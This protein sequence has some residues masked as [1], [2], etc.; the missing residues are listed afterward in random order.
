MPPRGTG[1]VTPFGAAD[2]FVCSPPYQGRAGEVLP[3]GRSIVTADTAKA[4]EREYAAVRFEYAVNGT[5]VSFVMGERWRWD[6]DAG[7]NPTDFEITYAREFR[8]DGAR[9]R[10]LNR[11]LDPAALQESGQLVSLRDTWSDYSGDSVYA[12]YSFDG[13]APEVSRIYEPGV[14]MSVDPTAVAG[15]R[16][17]HADHLGT[18]RFTSDG[19]TGAVVDS[20][21][22]EALGAPIDG[23]NH[24]YGYAG[25]YGY[26]SHDIDEV[27][28]LDPP[29]DPATAFPFLHVGARY[30]DP[31]TGRF[32]QRDPIGIAG[33]LNVYA[34][35]YNNP[36]LRTDPSGNGFW[37]GNN[38]FHDWIAR[39]FWMHPINP[40]KSRLPKMGD[41]EACAW[42]AGYTA[43]GTVALYRGGKYLARFARIHHGPFKGHMGGAWH[44]HIG[45]RAG[46]LGR[47]HLPQQF[48]GWWGNL[49]SILRR[50]WR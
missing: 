6:P 21:A 24:R 29:L 8:Y 30:Y 37:D 9:Q 47:Y 3:D 2:G 12:D 18:T 27:A 41:A 35:V 45:R 13:G 5:A 28:A 31:A 20:S 43:V 39:K 46:E 16:Y 22:Y 19:A 44:F 38:A 49:K 48:R 11:Q 23:A 42:V 33:G 32:L 25:A 1:R 10:Y 40:A 17:Y 34:Y 36:V 15:T 14:G 4:G 50:K 26:Q 7:G